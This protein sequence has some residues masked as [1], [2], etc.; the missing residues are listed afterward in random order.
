MRE[1]DFGKK[2]MLYD[3]NYAEHPNHNHIICSDCE[4]IVEFESAKID[5]LESEIS[6]RL[7]FSVKSQRLQ[8]TGDCEQ[9]KKLGTCKNRTCR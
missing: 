4:R 5:K 6:H 9:L 1:I 8:I 3:P 7:G 2:C